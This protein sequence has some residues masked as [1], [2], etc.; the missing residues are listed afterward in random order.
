MSEEV[1]PFRLQMIVHARAASR[2]ILWDKLTALKTALSRM[3]GAKYYEMAKPVTARNYYLCGVP[4]GGFQERDFRHYI[5][6]QN[7][8][9]LIPLTGEVDAELSQAEALYHTRSGSVFGVRSLIDEMP[10]HCLVSGWSGGGKS[11]FCQDVLVQTAPLYG[12]TVIVDDGLSYPVTA[13]LLS[14]DVRTFV[15]EAG[16]TETLN[17]LDPRGVLGSQHRADAQA[18][19]MNMFGREVKPVQEAVLGRCMRLFYE[20]WY[21]GWKKCFPAVSYTHLTLPTIYS[22]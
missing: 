4:G 18:V 13:K 12:F 1:L 22:V 14:E 3:Q 20:D 16:G 9:N 6:D 15:F 10:Q 5:E 11:V 21:E 19:A 2:E 7:L 17:Y 8:A